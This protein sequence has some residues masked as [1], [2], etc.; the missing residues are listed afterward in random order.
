MAKNF[1]LLPAMSIDR[2]IACNLCRGAVDRERFEEFIRNDV[3]PRCTPF[4]GPRSVLVMDNAAIHCDPVCP[5][6]ILL[7]KLLITD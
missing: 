4:L 7:I 6:V 5:N 1:S 2:Y 3:L